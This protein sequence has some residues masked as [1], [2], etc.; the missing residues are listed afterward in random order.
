MDTT[1]LLKRGKKI[2]LESRERN[3]S[4]RERGGGEERGSDSDMGGDGGEVQRVRKL[5]GGV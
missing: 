1:V 4:G 3:G 2:I 5:N